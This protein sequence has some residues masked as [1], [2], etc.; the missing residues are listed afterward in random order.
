[1]TKKELDKQKK[2]VRK[3]LANAREYGLPVKESDFT[4]MTKKLKDEDIWVRHLLDDLRN[5]QI[6]ILDEYNLSSNQFEVMLEV[7]EVLEY[8]TTYSEKKTSPELLRKDITKG[9]VKDNVVIVSKII[10]DMINFVREEQPIIEMFN[11]KEGVN[12]D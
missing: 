2:L 11:I 12:N 4:E 8:N 3:L 5:N 1:M 10:S 7:L 9:Y 6:L